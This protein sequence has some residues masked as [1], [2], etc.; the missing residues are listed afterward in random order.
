MI[1]E[2]FQNMPCFYVFIL[3]FACAGQAPEHPLQMP[4]PAG[5][6]ISGVRMVTE[7]GGHLAW[8]KKI[9]KIAFNRLGA[10]GYFDL[11]VMN[12][13]GGQIMGLVI[14]NRPDTRKRASGIIVLIDP[15]Y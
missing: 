1:N 5:K 10:D 14:T 11:W 15:V 13:D 8:S 3:L 4:V 9:N 7:D 2:W 12:P 6:N